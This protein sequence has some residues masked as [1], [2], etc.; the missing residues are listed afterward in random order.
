MP[1]AGEDSHLGEQ[2]FSKDRSCCCSGHVSG[3]GSSD[4][5]VFHPLAITADA[6]VSRKACH[7]ACCGWRRRAEQGQPVTTQKPAISRT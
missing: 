2:L 4:I 1:M 3:T 5:Y 7:P 6:W